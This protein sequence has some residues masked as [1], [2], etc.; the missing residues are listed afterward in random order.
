MSSEVQE[1]QERR[2]A[3]LAANDPEFA[4]A[5]PDQAVS[6][7][8]RGGRAHDSPRWS[9]PCWRAIPTGPRWPSART[10]WSKTRRP[11]ARQPSCCPGSTRSP[12][13][14]WPTASASCPARWPTGWCRPVT[15]SAFWASPASTT[16]PSTSRW[17]SSAPC[18]SRCRPARRSRSCS[19]SSL[20]TEPTVFAASVDYLSDAVD[21][22]LAG[23]RGGP[24][25]RTAGGLRLPQ[26]ARRQPR[27]AAERPRT[28]GRPAADHRDAQRGP[29]ARRD[30]CPRPPPS[31]PAR[32]T[33]W[34]C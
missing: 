16:P 14:S 28:A 4:A 13:A 9:R 7:C 29:R 6:R 34:R 11:G 19:R 24:H 30:S 21:V 12:T 27:G 20:E 31:S 25:A 15:G 26:R 18:R 5:R 33:R 22:I 10:S 1:D 23:R 32:T 8:H 17:A 2:A 3:E